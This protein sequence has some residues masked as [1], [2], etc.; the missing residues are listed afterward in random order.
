LKELWVSVLLGASLAVVMMVRAHFTSPVLDVTLG[1]S[2][3]LLVMVIFSGVTGALLP[4]FAR[5]LKIDP[6]FM[7][8]PVVATIMDVMGVAIYFYVVSM[9][10]K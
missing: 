9:F 1:V 5:L 8:G 6:A 10:I 4:F 7:A 2:C 3:A